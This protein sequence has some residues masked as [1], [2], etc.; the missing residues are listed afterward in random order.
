MQKFLIRLETNCLQIFYFAGII[1]II[2]LYICN[3][4]WNMDSYVPE[5]YSEL[6]V[7]PRASCLAVLPLLL[8]VASI[9]FYR[10]MTVFGETFHTEEET[11][12]LKA[13]KMILANT[14]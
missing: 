5:K 7:V 9:M 6:E 8:M 1:L 11:I 12:Y 3:L 2:S 13:N 10:R 4:L 14:N